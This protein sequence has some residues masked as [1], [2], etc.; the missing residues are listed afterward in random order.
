MFR[1]NPTRV[2]ALGRLPGSPGPAPAGGGIRFAKLSASMPLSDRID[3]GLRFATL[4]RRRG[5]ST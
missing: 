3:Q 4:R 5:E 1:P 2:P